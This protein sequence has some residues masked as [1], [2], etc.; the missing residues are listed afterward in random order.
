MGTMRPIRIETA[1]ENIEHDVRIKEALNF[2]SWE[3]RSVMGFEGDTIRIMCE[4]IKLGDKPIPP[5]GFS[6]GGASIDEILET[7][8]TGKLRHFLL[9]LSIKSETISEYF[10]KGDVAIL[11]GS[12]LTRAGIVI[13]LSGRQAS[14]MNLVNSLRDSIVIDRVSL[15][16]GAKGMVESGPTLHQ[17]KILKTAYL[18]GWY[19]TPKKVSIRDLSERMGISKSSIA[20]QLV[21]AEGK[22]VGTYIQKSPR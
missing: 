20:E 19:E 9:V 13:Q 3:F 15:S 17:L 18:H 11:A 4:A 10:H 2:I 22:V 8:E 14:V 1:L 6:V 16:Q 5:P 12:N 21:K 7:W